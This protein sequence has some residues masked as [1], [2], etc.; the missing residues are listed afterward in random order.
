MPKQTITW[1][2]GGKEQSA[3]LKPRTTYLLP[4]GYKVEMVKK[5]SNALSK[6][7]GGQAGQYEKWHLKGTGTN[8]QNHARV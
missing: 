2:A 8:W 5:G 1:T 3:N 6:K 7:K 4:S